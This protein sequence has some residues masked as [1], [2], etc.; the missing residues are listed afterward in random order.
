MGFSQCCFVIFYGLQK[1]VSLL[2]RKR[3][4]YTLVEIMVVATVI[5]I[6]AAF[7][8]PGLSLVIERMRAEEGRQLLLSLLSAQKRY[9]LEH[10]GAYTND[11]NLLDLDLRPSDNFSTIRIFATP[12]LAQVSRSGDLYT[13]S[14]D[15]QARITCTGAH[16]S[17]LGF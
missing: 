1:K 9:A 17:N 8:I 2:K 10:G 16:C 7:A 14:I 13:L 15:G 3:H 11:L 4:A 12:P 6:I 5:S